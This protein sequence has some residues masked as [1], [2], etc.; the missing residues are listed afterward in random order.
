MTDALSTTALVT[1]AGRGIGRAVARRLSE[2]GLRVA[3]VARTE[4]DLDAT[5]AG[6]PSPTLRIAADVTDQTAVDAA[7]GE[8]ER[9]WGP[10]GVLVA[11]AGAGFSARL[12]RTG[13]EDWYR[14][15]ELN[16]TAPFRC[17]RR[18]VPAMRTGGYGRIVVI[19][20]NAAQVGEPYV[21]AYAASKHGVLGLVRATSAELAADGNEA[22]TCWPRSASQSWMLSS[23]AT[24]M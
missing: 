4:A 3:L 15:L 18:A 8:V 7:F 9:A 24:A 14:M 6:C 23:T 20:S 2:A 11:S 5:A 17:L 12:E 16:L 22:P 21:A 13:D 10:V 19:A 1:G